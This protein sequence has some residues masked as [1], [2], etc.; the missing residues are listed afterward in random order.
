MANKDKAIKY[1]LDG[2]QAILP[3]NT[4]VARYK[5][6]LEGLSKKDLDQY[7]KD[8]KEG[9]KWITLT[10]PNFGKSNLDIE[11]NFK[12][13][14]KLGLEFYKKVWMPAEGDNPQYL[15]PIPRLCVHQPFRLASQR[16]DK[17]R[18]V[19]KHQRSLN[20]L[21]GQAT[22]ASKGAGYSFPEIRLARAMGLDS[23]IVEMIK[24]RGGDLR[25]HA[26]LSASLLRTGRAS[27]NALKHYASGVE[28]TARI[29]TY[30][31]CMHLRMEI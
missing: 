18:A 9:T 4:D 6:Y 27:I 30:F 16:V 10:A 13:A 3:G 25:G 17:K 29:R 1:I 23:S 5:R 12:V 24:Y 2:L 14:E 11:R 19:P 26:A 20:A 28:S 22:N 31:N 21:T 8:L 7:F 15:S